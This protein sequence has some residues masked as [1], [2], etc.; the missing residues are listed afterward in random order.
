MPYNGN[1][2]V[3]EIKGGTYTIK[4]SF[5][6]LENYLT[7]AKRTSPAIPYEMMITD[8]S[9]ETDTAKWVTRL[10]YPVM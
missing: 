9:K 7:D 10:Y 1:V 6:Q 8:R 2:L 4:K 5:D 3:T